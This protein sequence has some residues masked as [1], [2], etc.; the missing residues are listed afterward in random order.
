MLGEHRSAGDHQ[1]IDPLLRRGSHGGFEIRRGAYFEWEQ[2][3][4][5]RASHCLHRLGQAEGTDSRI[6]EEGDPRRARRSF[7]QQLQLFSSYFFWSGRQTRD[8]AARAREALD[9]PSGD[10]IT[11]G[12][13]HHDRDRRGRLSGGL[14]RCRPPGRKNDI[15]RQVDEFRRQTRKSLEPI[16]G[17]STLDDDILTLDPAELAKPP[18]KGAGDVRG[19]GGTRTWRQNSDPRNLC[20]PLP[21][22]GERRD[23]EAASQHAEERSSVHYRALTWPRRLGGTGQAA[24]SDLTTAGSPA[25]V[26][27]AGELRQRR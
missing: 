25:G 26:T 12:G 24:S 10:R 5:E 16:L 27:A 15:H 1:A 11:G 23:E 21:L 17:K 19:R 13:H 2:L 7:P 6:P 8:V 3:H 9:E 20:R 4:F 22:G 18:E 14:K